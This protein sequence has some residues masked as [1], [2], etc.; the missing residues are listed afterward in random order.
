MAGI[1]AVLKISGKPGFVL[2]RDE[3]YTGVL[4]DDLVTKGV[5]E[6]YRMFTSRAEYRILLRQDNADFRLTPK[7]IDLGIATEE[8]KR[9]FLERTRMR[10][11]LVK[12][13]N[14]TGA[15]PLEVNAMLKEKGTNEIRQKV[16][17][18]ELLLRPQVTILDLLGVLKCSSPEFNE[19]DAFESDLLEAIEI[20]FK[21]RGYI[22]REKLLAEK[23]GRLN[24]IRIDDGIEFDTLLSISTEGRFKLKKYKPKTLGE[25]ARI[26]GISPS[27]LNVLLLYMGR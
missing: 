3:A 20:E 23:M 21:Y 25:A 14:E 4:I 11:K 7:A 12:Q 2:G 13:L 6:P 27:D 26:S 17:F 22:E 9:R 1:N 19:D 16:R 18:A 24:N 5:D 10:S 15:S 8:R